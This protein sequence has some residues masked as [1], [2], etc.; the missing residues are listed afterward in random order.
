MVIWREVFFAKPYL[1][2]HYGVHDVARTSSSIRIF[3]IAWWSTIA[4][5]T[6]ESAA[7]EIPFNYLLSRNPKMSL[8]F[9]DFTSAVWEFKEVS[10][11][12][13]S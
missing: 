13:F 11:E 10:T 2:K 7:L 12:Y 5:T 4:I 1:Y 3:E 9:F 8:S 6:N